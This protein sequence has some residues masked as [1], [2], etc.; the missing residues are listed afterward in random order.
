M[1]FF[2]KY[3]AQIVWTISVLCEI[4][5]MGAVIYLDLLPAKL[6]IVA[7]IIMVLLAFLNGLLLL[8]RVRKIK[9]KKNTWKRT[10][11][12]I[13]SAVI[14]LVSVFGSFY[15][16]KAKNTINTVTET[17]DVVATLGVYVLADDAAESIKD[18]KGYEYGYL[19]TYSSE[20]N[21]YAVSEINNQ[22]SSTISVEAEDNIYSL[23][24]SLYSGSKQAIILD[25]A[26]VSILTEQE[27]SS[28]EEEESSTES[29]T[30]LS[31]ETDTKLLYEINITSDDND[32]SDSTVDKDV[33]NDS[34]VIYIS[35]SDTRNT[36]LTTSRSDVNILAQVNPT[37]HEILLLNTPRDYYVANPAGGGSKDKLTHCGIYGI[38]NSMEALEELYDVEVDYYVQINFTGFK[39]LI[40]AIGGITVESQYSFTS[41]IYGGTYSY[42]KGS[43]TLS[44]AE[45]LAFARERYEVPGGDETRGVHQMAVIQAVID[46]VTSSTTIL[47]NYSDIMTSLEGMFVTSFS[48][49]EISSIIKMQLDDNP[50]WNI[51]SFA[52]SGTGG[53]STT[54]SNPSQRSYVMYPDESM[55][56]FAQK[57]LDAVENG[58]SLT[59]EDVTYTTSE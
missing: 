49:N 27:D 12:L 29:S 41:Y 57:L 34:F 10:V 51:H 21:E 53:K 43:N 24:E 46:K 40:D 44:G 3:I 18:T 15:V 20:R 33:T 48:S 56:A 19:N 26:F 54:Y 8:T 45:A 1:S 32:D 37:T 5:F 2:K 22:V 28:S 4:F 6:M 42:T 9:G 38:E 13:L 30:Y 14:I 7:V 39:N 52:V 47:S 31:F 35:G 55:V 59:D 17:S 25:E 16:I 58:E 50:T 36:T 23:A 11:G